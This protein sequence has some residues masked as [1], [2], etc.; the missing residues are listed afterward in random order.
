MER[1]FQKCL[2]YSRHYT[3][4][5]RNEPTLG[6]IPAPANPGSLEGPQGDLSNRRLPRSQA[7]SEK[8][9]NVL[10]YMS[11]HRFWLTLGRKFPKDS[12]FLILFLFLLSTDIFGG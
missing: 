1:K 12:N 2:N 3:Y 8:I 10:S 6:E 11:F 4:N 5:T 9:A 7:T